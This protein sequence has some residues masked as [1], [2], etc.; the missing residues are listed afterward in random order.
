MDRR[1]F[2]AAAAG[3]ATGLALSNSAWSAPT[4]N[5]TSHASLSIFDFGAVGDGETDDSAAFNKALET[6][7]R[8]GRTVLVPGR[9]YA[10]ARP[11]AW[12]STNHVG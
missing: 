4:E 3:A 6:A 12:V 1:G 7:A 10:I 5:S 8:E 11:I 9:T 2:V